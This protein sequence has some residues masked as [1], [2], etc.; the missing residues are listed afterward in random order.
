MVLLRIVSDNESQMEKIAGWLLQ[1]KLAID[2]NL[3]RN[4]ERWNWHKEQIQKLSVFLLEA[5]TKALLFPKIDQLILEKFGDN[6]PEIY[7]LPIV[8][9][10]WE[11][12]KVLKDSV[13]RI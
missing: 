10:D 1:D 5:K 12:A 6:V 8:D 9:M 3:K 2:V 4:I 13:E 11:Q 7:S